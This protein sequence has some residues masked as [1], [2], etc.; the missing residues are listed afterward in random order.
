MSLLLD[1]LLD[2]SRVTR[3]TL[4]LRIQAT[5]LAAVVDAAVETARPLIEAKGH[6]FDLRDACGVGCIRRLTRCGSHRFCR[7]CSQTLRSTLIR[8]APF[9]CGRPAMPSK[10]RSRSRIPASAWRR[11]PSRTSSSC[12][13]KCRPA[14]PARR[15]DLGIGLALAKGLVKLHGGVIE[16]RSDGLGKG[17][18]FIVRLPRRTILDSRQ[19]DPA[20]PCWRPNPSAPHLDSG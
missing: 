15:E 13:R 10:S 7:T 1:D 18:E 8:G 19:P 9:V 4:E 16:A 12:S 5:D 20:I 2:V 3:G 14:E 17:S 11:K 6:Q